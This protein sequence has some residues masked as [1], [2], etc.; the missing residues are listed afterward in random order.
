MNKEIYSGNLFK[1]QTKY[2][3][4]ET[5]KNLLPEGLFNLPKSGFGVPVGDWLRNELKLELLDLTKDELLIKQNI[6]NIKY[7][8]HL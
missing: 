3:L 6:F 2:I 1:L 8:I 7:Y 4:K 5:F